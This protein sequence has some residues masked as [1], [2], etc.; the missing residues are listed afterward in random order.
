MSK[1]AFLVFGLLFL[2][3]FGGQI[4]AQSGSPAEDNAVPVEVSPLKVQELYRSVFYGC[5][6]LPARRSVHRS[7]ISGSLESLAVKTGQR[8]SPGD[9]LFTV[10]RE[11]TGRSYNSAAV[12]AY[13]GGIIAEYELQSGDP[14]QENQAILTVLDDSAYTGEILV[15]DKDIRTV[16]IGDSC[17]VFEDREPTSVTGQVTLISPEPEYESGL[18]PVELRFPRSP[19]L[20]IGRFLRVELR[21][22]PYRGLAVPSQN[23][24]R[25]YGEDHLYIVRDNTVELRPINVGASYG[26]LVTITGGVS[27]GELFVTSSTRRITDGAAVRIVEGE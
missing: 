15:S 6:L 7:P 2:L 24:V 22:E 11:L 14:V 1:H 8:V 21:K 10:R 18:F 20:F 23:I 13:D 25:K 27:G 19:G 4:P 3:F 9:L 17:V 26:D 16:K 12:R 5:R